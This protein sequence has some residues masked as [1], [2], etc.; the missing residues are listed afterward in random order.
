VCKN[1]SI[2]AEWASPLTCRWGDEVSTTHTERQTLLLV[3]LIH[4]W[5]ATFLDRDINQ[6]VLKEDQLKERASLRRYIE[7]FLPIANN[8]NVE[9]EAIYECCRWASLI[10][11]AVDKSCIPI[12]VAA[13]QIR[14]SPRLTTRLSM[15]DLSQLWGN[16]KGLLF[17]V[18]AVCHFAT[19]GRCYALLCRAL[20]ARFAQE[21]AM[22][23]CCH[24]I[25]LKPLWRLKQFESFCCNLGTVRN[26]PHLLIAN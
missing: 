18:T 8:S 7:G 1:C 9:I 10:L 16:R 19:A 21:L 6:F 23:D 14:I 15:T 22:S 25:A 20:L 17:W 26:E 3:G 24:H 4:K 13:K 12:H 11:L 2:P 5:L